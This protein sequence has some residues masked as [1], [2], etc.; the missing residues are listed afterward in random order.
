MSL[1]CHFVH[2][3]SSHERVNLKH[4]PSN[5]LHS[6]LVAR[7]IWPHLHFFRGLQPLARS[8]LHPA[9][10][11]QTRAAHAARPFAWPELSGLGWRNPH[12]GRLAPVDPLQEE[13]SAGHL[14]WTTEQMHRETVSSLG[15]VFIW[16]K[17]T[18]AT[19]PAVLGATNQLNTFSRRFVLASCFE[20]L[21]RTP[22]ELFWLDQVKMT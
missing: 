2:I 6:V 11:R 13:N 21:K 8:R 1:M 7:V 3:S 16:H 20:P 10:V 4:S 5:V 22:N 17:Q 14:S 12:L 19:C 18:W 9:P 15:S